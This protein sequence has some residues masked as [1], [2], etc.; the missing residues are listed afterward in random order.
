M[1][2]GGP[3]GLIAALRD[4]YLEDVEGFELDVAALVSQEV[5]HELEVLRL[6]DVFRHD[7]EVVPVEKQ[8]P[9]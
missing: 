7:G 4:S 9:K 8:L 6:A 5:H 3:R 2:G 1:F